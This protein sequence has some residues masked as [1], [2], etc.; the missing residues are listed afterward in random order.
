MNPKE[1]RQTKSE[2]ELAQVFC[3]SSIPSL[4]CFNWNPMAVK[5]AI[6]LSMC[7]FP[8]CTSFL[9]FACYVSSLLILLFSVGFT[10][11]NFLLWLTVGGARIAMVE[12]V[13]ILFARISLS[14]P[15][16]LRRARSDSVCSSVEHRHHYCA[17]LIACWVL[18]HPLLDLVRANLLLL[19]Q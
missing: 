14:R 8:L 2:I 19:E 5:L 15:A 6:S 3:N 11:G 16:C 1:N 18:L 12:L 9:C 4:M 7:F 13:S 10:F 17:R